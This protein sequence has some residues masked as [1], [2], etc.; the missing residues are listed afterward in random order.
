MAGV[1]DLVTV[2]KNGVTA[3][4]SLVQELIN[5]KTAYSNFVGTSS[6][7]GIT[8]DTAIVASSGRLVTVSVI[9]AAAG[10][11]IYDSATV[12]GA[13]DDNAIY[14]IPNSTGAVAVNFPFTNGLVVK[15]ASS[16]VVSI[17]YSEDA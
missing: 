16:S 8:G 7:T 6:T 17:S 15:P 14:T 13:S 1:D 3:V 9:T 5:F 12:A 11:K 2:Q 4:N 10:G